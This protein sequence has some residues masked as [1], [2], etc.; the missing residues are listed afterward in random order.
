MEYFEPRPKD[1]NKAL[2]PELRETANKILEFLAE[3][4]EID[5]SVG[6]LT[7]TLELKGEEAARAVKELISL[8]ALIE[9]EAFKGLP[10]HVK[11]N[12]QSQYVKNIMR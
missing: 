10:S 11:L 5:Y 1:I 8:E 9:V 6:E 7:R 4:P 12:P 2:P 3:S